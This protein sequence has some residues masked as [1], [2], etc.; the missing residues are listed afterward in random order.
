MREL[1][2]AGLVAIVFGLGSYYATREV[3]A[4]S[5]LN[6]GAG[7]LA[8]LVALAI[9]A[10]RLRFA[11]GPHVRPVLLRGVAW[12]VGAVV[13]GVALERGADASGAR[14]D[15]TF[16]Q[17]FALSQ[18]TRDKLASL[19]K[20]VT[21]ILF[22]HPDDPRVRRTRL[23]LE[24]LARA[25]QD[26]FAWRARV[27][28]DEPT[29][30]DRF[31]VGSSN[32]VVLQQGERFETISRPRE[33]TL[34]EGLHRVDRSERGTVVI[35]RGEGQGDPNRGD[36]AGF[37]GVAAAL[38]T[39][40][41]RVETRMSSAIDE[42]G[43]DVDLVLSL[44]PERALLPGAIDALRRYLARGGSLVALLEPGRETGIEALLAEYGI[45][46]GDGV[47]VDP[48]SGPVTD[49]SVPGLNVIAFNYEAEPI[50]RGLDPNRV[51][52]FP[53]V[54]PLRLRKPQ[55]GDRLRQLV[56]SS[57]RAWVSGDLGWLD[58]RSGRPERADE[59]TG[60]QILA[61]SGRYPR[62]NG[63]T[64]IVAFGDAD[65]AS[66]ENL[67]AVFN[68]DLALNAAHWASERETA[69]TL[70]PKVRD[71]IQF[72]LPVNDSVR[73]LYGVGVLL[74]ELLLIAGGIA[75]LRRRS[76]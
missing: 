19:S 34:F 6:L 24:E 62:E 46:A 35:L 36:P 29:D 26:R 38:D 54:R 41:Y 25:S 60:Y 56:L 16:E 22:Y 12:I 65:F 59:E 13:L 5:L 45:E 20:P 37:G 47:V 57:H 23:L 66:N 70:R 63:E 17:S 75:W 30:A 32:T 55:A 53:G 49:S 48:A 61:A 52:Y 40:G 3:G 15:W 51:S 68:L 21:A 8:L 76:A 44:A 9:G 4:F 31:G 71:T 14:F 18:G 74:P 2:L 10:R 58:R 43:D 1:G 28:D 69:I 42:I 73:A 72:P 27:L 33:G 64:R 11:G 39:E 50:T 7:S 67:R